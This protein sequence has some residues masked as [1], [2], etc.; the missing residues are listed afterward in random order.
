M[1]SVWIPCVV[2]IEV[3]PNHPTIDFPKV[4]TVQITVEPSNNG[5]AWDLERLYFLVCSLLGGLSSFGVSFI[6][7]SPAQWWRV[8]LFVWL[9][10]GFG[11]DWDPAQDWGVGWCPHLRAVWLDS[12]HL[13]RWHCD[14]R[15]GLWYVC[16]QYVY[17]RFP[18]RSNIPREIYGLYVLYTY[19]VNFN[20]HLWHT[21]TIN[22]HEQE[23]ECSNATEID[24]SMYT[25][26]TSAVHVHTLHLRAVSSRW[27]RHLRNGLW[28][29]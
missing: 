16:M 1:L 18:L 21:Q 2:Y 12:G 9:L 14:L 29:V 27:H 24:C 23:T 11:S 6:V 10:L 25:Y 4:T 7:Y 17:S 15:N 28:Y 26:I 3:L 5:H 19:A 20:V 22:F 13:N 8:F